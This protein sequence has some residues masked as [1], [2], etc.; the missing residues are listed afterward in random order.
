MYLEQIFV[1]SLPCLAVKSV[2]PIIAISFYRNT[3]ILSAKM[4][5]VHKALGE[6]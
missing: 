2:T 6:I 4:Y 3:A 1:K 5:R